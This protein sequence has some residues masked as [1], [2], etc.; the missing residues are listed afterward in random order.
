VGA[1]AVN[2]VVHLELHTGDREGAQ[3]FYASLCGW[4]P[5]PVETGAGTYWSL[6]LSEGVGGGVVENEARRPLWLPYVEVADIVTATERG[7]ALGARVVIEPREGPVGY[8]SLIATPAG[9]E[10]AL[11]QPKR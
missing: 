6:A 11:W 7:R 3:A 1:H 5:H 8:R 4:R 10:L 9:A 2:P